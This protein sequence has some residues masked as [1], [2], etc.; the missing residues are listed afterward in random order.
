MTQNRSRVS[1]TLF[2]DAELNKMIRFGDEEAALDLI[3][4]GAGVDDPT[5]QGIPSL[6]STI[7][8]GLIRVA[9]ALLEAGSDV[10]IQDDTGNTGVLI[11]SSRGKA[12]FVMLFLDYGA[13]VNIVGSYGMTALM[14]AVPVQTKIVEALIRAGAD[15]NAVD[16]RKET[17]LRH[18]ITQYNNS[19]LKIIR[20]LLESGANVH[21]KD[22][23]GR[24][25]LDVAIARGYNRIADLLEEW[26]T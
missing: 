24:T 15:V 18:A 10:N 23:E 12:D 9:E 8:G 16:N 6:L 13:D 14:R 26:G 20:L 19:H 17:V 3:H 25:A 5:L 4:H 2:E 11:A 7:D 1:K 22:S 21:A